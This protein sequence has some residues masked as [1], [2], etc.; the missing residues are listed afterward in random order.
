MLDMVQM[1]QVVMLMNSFS[2]EYRKQENNDD[3]QNSMRDDDD[4]LVMT[5][6]I[7]TKT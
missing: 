7:T 6:V 2:A 4:F 5:S 3:L 1:V